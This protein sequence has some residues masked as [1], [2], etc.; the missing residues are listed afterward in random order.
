MLAHWDEVEGRTTDL[1]ELRGTWRRLARAAG[2]VGVGANRIDLPPGGRSTPAHTHTGEEE[3]FFVLGGEGRSWQ[4]GRTYRVGAGDFLLHAPSGPAHTLIAG[5]AG[6]QALAFGTRAKAETGPLP[7]AGTAWVG[8]TWIELD[9]GEHP[10]A[11][12]VAA[13]PL[14]V[15]EPEDARPPTIVAL[16]DVPALERRRGDVGHVRRNVGEALGARQTALRHLVVLPSALTYPPHCHSADE[17]VFIVLEGEG[18]LLLGDEEHP[19]RAGSVVSRPPGTGVAHAFRAGEGG[20]TLLAYG[21]RVP[22]DIAFFPRS[23]KVY[24]R[25]VE[26]IFRI[27]SVDYWDGEE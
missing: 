9:P 7:R 25:G 15:P 16:A 13:G 17:E 19:V 20:L 12:E 3:I 4:D 23:N 6:L 27:E 21:T 10:W 14:E 18:L 5:D 1:G 8:D 24:L 22:N 2:A 11:R 26:A